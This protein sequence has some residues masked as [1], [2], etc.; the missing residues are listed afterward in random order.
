MPDFSKGKIYRLVCDDPDLLYI[1]STCKTL[2]QRKAGHVFEAKHNSP[3]KCSS[4]QI[5]EA[6]NLKIE[7]IE[8]YP[9]NTKHEL[10]MRERYWIQ[11][12]KCVN[13]Y[14]R[15][16]T[17]E[18]EK[19]EKKKERDRRYYENHKDE[20]KKKTRQYALANPEQTAQ[21][22]REYEMRKKGC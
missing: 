3:K 20:I 5:Y 8:A 15:V 1:G 14:S 19:K 16:T 21:Y 11:N 17:T 13:R 18:I 10:H 9:C 22:K 7:L 12:S 2:A 6:G 4:F